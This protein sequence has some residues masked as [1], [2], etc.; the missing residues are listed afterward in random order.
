MA[1]NQANLVTIH[2][3]LVDFSWN[4]LSGS[5]G[6]KAE[7]DALCLDIKTYC[8]DGKWDALDIHYRAVWLG[9][10]SRRLARIV[11]DP[12]TVIRKRKEKGD[13]TQ[14]KLMATVA[15]DGVQILRLKF[16]QF[17]INRH[18]QGHYEGQPDWL[19]GKE[20]LD[21][22]KTLRGEPGLSND[23]R[24]RVHRHS[25]Q[26]VALNNRGFALHCLANVVPARLAFDTQ[27]STDEAERLGRSFADM[28]L[29]LGASIP[30]TRRR[31][32]DWDAMIPSSFTAVPRTRNSTDVAY[33]IK[34][35][36]MAPGAAPDHG[37]EIVMNSKIDM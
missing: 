8:L 35:I 9:E 4:A 5:P 37:N 23:L 7:L 10:I 13:I 14:E 30:E 25:G 18:F 1:L 33:T 19:S 17:T 21:V 28:G 20:I 16:S 11:P 31:R 34:A 6:R 26:W 22:A 3:L 27:L 12:G 32:Q 24:I 2:E 15:A 29:N 36:S